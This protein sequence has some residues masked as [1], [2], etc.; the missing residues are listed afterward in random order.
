MWSGC[1]CLS[2]RLG[3]WK[4]TFPHPSWLCHSLLCDLRQV[5]V[6]L[7]PQFPIFK[8]SSLLV[9]HLLFMC[10]HTCML[11]LNVGCGVLGKCSA[12]AASQLRMSFLEWMT[13]KALTLVFQ[14]CFH[15]S[16]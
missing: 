1:H 2:I 3:V 13:S 7:E 11:G 6:F 15:H 8:M 9:I 4:A 5:I 10:V 16:V 12:A 14:I